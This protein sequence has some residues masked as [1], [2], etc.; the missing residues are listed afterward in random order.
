MAD[1][2]GIR[3]GIRDAALTFALVIGLLYVGLCYLFWAYEPAFVFAQ[4]PR[5]PIAPEAAGLKGF[6]EVAVTTDDGARLF[7]WWRPPEP[8]HGAIV[9]LT[10]TGVTLI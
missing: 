3:R 6:S 9:F 1:R 7:G 2:R 10:G 5:P 4:L 8:G